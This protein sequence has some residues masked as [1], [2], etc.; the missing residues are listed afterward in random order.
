[1]QKY[2]LAYNIDVRPDGMTREEV[3][4]NWAGA[5]AII[6]TSLIHG[7]DGS[8]SYGLASVDGRTGEALDDDDLFSAW[9]VTA[10]RLADSEDLSEGKRELAELVF[11]TMRAA[12]LEARGLLPRG[13]LS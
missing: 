8:T 4:E 12:I 1:M 13:P 11:E 2:H 10:R 5:T 9:C 3:P 6:L 7:E